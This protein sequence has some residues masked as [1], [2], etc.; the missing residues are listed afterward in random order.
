MQRHE[1]YAGTQTAVDVD[2]CFERPSARR[3]AHDVTGL[4]AQSFRVLGRNVERLAAMERREIAAALD[5]GVE[6][7]EAPTRRQEKREFLVRLFDGTLVMHD[8]ERREPA[9]LR[10]IVVPQSGVEELRARMVL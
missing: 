6:R 4:D 7:L 10:R 3:H 9:A 1:N 2:R 5:A 8:R